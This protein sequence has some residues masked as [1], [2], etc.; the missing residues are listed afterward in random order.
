MLLLAAYQLVLSLSDNPHN[1]NPLVEEKFIYCFG[2][3]GYSEEKIG[4]ELEK[5]MLMAKMFS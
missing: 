2:R 5:I 1:V 4:Q 3:V